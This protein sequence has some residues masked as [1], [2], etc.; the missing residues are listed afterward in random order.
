MNRRRF[1]NTSLGGLAAAFAES[2][3]AA[4]PRKTTLDHSPFLPLDQIEQL[5]SAET[6]DVQPPS[7][8]WLVTSFPHRT[9][10]HRTDHPNEI[11]MTNGL[12][13]RTWRLRPNAAT[14]GFDNLMTG[15]S[16]LRAVKPEAYVKLN[17][18]A[19]T[20][21]GGLLGQPNGAYLRPEWVDQMTTDPHS[22]HCT[23]F[24]T[25]NTKARFPWRRTRF[26]G[27]Q[28]WPAPGASL[29]L[30]FEPGTAGPSGINVFIHYEMFDGIPLL[31]KWLT[32]QNRSEERV[33]LNRFVNEILAVVE[34]E[35][36]VGPT[37]WHHPNIHVESDYAFGG[38]MKPS[39]SNQTAHWVPD[40]EY[41][42]QVNYDLQTP[43]LL[44][45]HPPIGPD[46]DILPGETFET[47][48]TYELIYDS[49]E[50]ERNGLALRRMYRT[51]APWVTE[52]PVFMHVTNDKPEAVRS[53]VDQAASVGFEMVIISF[54]T[55]FDPTNVSASSIQTM[56]ELAA[57]ANNKGVV[58][59]GYSLL[60]SRDVGAANDV[61]DPKTGTTG[62]AIFGHS[63]CLQSRWGIAYFDKLYEFIEKTGLGVLEHDGSYPGDVCASTH[64]PGHRGLLDSQWTQW[65]E[66]TKFYQWCRGRGVSLNVPD[67][68]FLNGSTKS[69]MGYR[70]TN[71]S[72]P[73]EQQLIIARQNIFDGTWQKTP[74]MGWMFV[75]LV[76]YH[77]GGATATIE[78]LHAH[79][80]VYAQI[81]AQLFGSGVQAAYR[82]Y[83]LYD[84]KETEALVK[85][86]VDFYKTYRPILNSD[87]IHVRRADGRDIDAILHVNPQLDIKGFAMVYNP[88]NVAITRTLTLPLY[89]TGIRGEARIRE[90]EGPLREYR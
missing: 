1:I 82:G 80:K 52:N 10:I 16:I 70:E 29:V 15:A 60:A 48:R 37:R 8:D 55:G 63:P 65:K 75:P 6:A 31:S 27:S 74:S 57:Y 88:L 2:D 85:K 78:P 24:S 56:K 76:Q 34:Y 41:K 62:G 87:I 61:I 66:I 9:R 67:W 90:Q 50:R 71:W 11:A 26:S 4:R 20:P 32:I 22:F 36:S 84:A 64:H 40:P 79:L 35:S 89:Y 43:C 14:V 19:E 7:A 13:R 58:L 81:L 3:A 53:A 12:I 72:L 47:Y 45:V 51:I 68:Y 77:G 25:G 59:G 28:P 17:W 23:G 86:W 21:V 30:R 39:N 44:H 54:G 46:V 83:Q 42:T 38:G 49:T 69:G 18:Q 33:R 5:S 73:R